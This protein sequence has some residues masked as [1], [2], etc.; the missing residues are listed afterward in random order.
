MRWWENRF[1]VLQSMLKHTSFSFLCILFSNIQ[2]SMRFP[3]FVLIIGKSHFQLEQPIPTTLSSNLQA[4][5]CRTARGQWSFKQTNTLP[6]I[7]RLIQRFS[8]KSSKQM[9]HTF[10]VWSRDLDFKTP[11]F[12]ASTGNIVSPLRARR[13]KGGQLNSKSPFPLLGSD[14]ARPWR[15]LTLSV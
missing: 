8:W 5:W 13:N 10:L 1:L 12:Q 11:G 15:V 14:L 9:A 3:H 6:L 2:F 7:W 4:W